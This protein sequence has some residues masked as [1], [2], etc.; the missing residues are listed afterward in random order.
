MNEGLAAIVRTETHNSMQT[1]PNRLTIALFLLWTAM[2]GVA[3]A[4]FVDQKP[5]PVESIGFAS[6]LTQS[7]QDPQVEMKK[8]RQR[9]HR[10]WQT[11]YQIRLAMSPVYGAALAGLALGAWRLATCRRGFPI[12]PGH[13]LLLTIGSLCLLLVSHPFLRSHFTHAYF[14]EFVVATLATIL[15]VAIA[16]A[17][18]EPLWRYALGLAAIGC[19]LVSVSFS[20]PSFESPALF[21]LGLLVLALVPFM[22]VLSTCVDIA[23]RKRYDA[24]HWIGIVALFGVVAHFLVNWMVARFTS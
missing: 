9:I 14:S 13:W 17:V 12:Q 15:F 3:L 1:S 21:G 6:F 2:T 18:R 10:R 5:P 22:A 7:G 24:L 16:I 23:N 19:G 8:A 20:S 4:Y 11:Q